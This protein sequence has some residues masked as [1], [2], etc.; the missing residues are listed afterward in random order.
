MMRQL[1]A[2]LE[3]IIRAAGALALEMRPWLEVSRKAD[4]SVVT[5]AD[6]AVEQLLHQE[7]SWLLPEAKF[8]GEERPLPIV[9]D[10][11][12]LWIV[13]PID[14]TDAYRHGLAYFGVSVGLLC[15]REMTAGAFYNPQLDEMFLA[16][17]GGGAQLNGERLHVMERERFDGDCFMFGPSDFHRFY[18]FDLPIKS[19]SLGSTAQHL[20]LVAAGR[21]CLAICRPRLWDVAAAALFVT[22]AGGAVLHI[23]GRPFLPVE[24][25]T[26]QMITPPLIAG[27][28][29]IIRDALQHLV[30][31]GP[32]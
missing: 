24:H 17:R 6:V 15:G 8:I 30:W 16:C 29:A 2:R 14:G 11:E 31:E 9:G 3:P 4:G 10:N 12:P 18:R 20:A 5:Q 25:L 28:E 27:P 26:G 32:R 23:D 19:R 7:L 13:D 21:A 22:E 1:L